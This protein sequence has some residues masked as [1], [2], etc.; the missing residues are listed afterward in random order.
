MASLITGGTG[1]VGA[2]LAHLLTEAGEEVVLFSRTMRASRIDDIGD[3]VKWVQGD[4][5]IWSHVLSTVKDNKIT[6]IYHTGAML[7]FVS[8]RDPRVHSAPTWLVRL[9]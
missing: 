4:L 5:G 2:E 6:E 9:M 3:K 8:E 1:L 7:S